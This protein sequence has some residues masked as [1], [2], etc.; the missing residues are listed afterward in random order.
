MLKW[1]AKAANADT[2]EEIEALMKRHTINWFREN[3]KCTCNAEDPKE[4]HCRKFHECMKE[5]FMEEGKFHECIKKTIIVQSLGR[6]VR[7]KKKDEAEAAQK[8][9][10]EAEAAQKAAEEVDQPADHLR[11]NVDDDTITS[12]DSL[13]KVVPMSSIA[14]D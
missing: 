4:C 5:E 10:D 6:K 3:T 13:A 8:A 2:E 1:I 7:V 11:I 12:N 9:A 14:N